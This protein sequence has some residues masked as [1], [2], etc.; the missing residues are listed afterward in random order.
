MYKPTVYRA[1][2]G[3]IIFGL[4]VATGL[5]AQTNADIPQRKEQ[6][7]AELSGAPGMEVVASIVEIRPGEST[8]LHFHHGVETAYV[9]D[10]ALVETPNGQQTMLPTGA[11]LLNAREV[12]HGAFKNVDS[13]GLRF[14]TVHIVDKGK[15]L[16][17][18]TK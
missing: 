10:G 14:F 3:I 11:T 5:V 8:E 17:D 4:G 16:Y 2:L 9:I 15:P 12:K 1:T 18:F 13:K 7:R 6:R